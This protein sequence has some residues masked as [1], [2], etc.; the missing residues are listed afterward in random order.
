M[1]VVVARKRIP[2]SLH[3]ECVAKCRGD[4]GQKIRRRLPLMQLGGMCLHYA[5]CRNAELAIEIKA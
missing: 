3:R 4:Y 1:R 2:G 5:I